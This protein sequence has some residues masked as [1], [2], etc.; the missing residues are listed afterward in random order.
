LAVRFLEQH[1]YR[2]VA[3][4][5]R[6]PGGEI[7]VVCVDGTILVFVEVKRRLGPAFGPA[8]AAVDGRKR[9]TLRAIAADYAQIVAPQAR[10]RFDI[11]TIDGNRLA[12]HRN[13][14]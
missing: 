12:L 4:N 8:I 6:A 5:V 11:V 14:F 3:R 10:I 2:V 9:R 13:A 1:G 7:D